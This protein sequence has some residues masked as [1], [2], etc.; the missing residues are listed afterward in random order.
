M[1]RRRAA[2]PRDLDAAS[3]I[4][5]ARGSE[6]ESDPPPPSP[7]PLQAV[8]HVLTPF[9]SDKP[10]I[11]IP[12]SPDVGCVDPGVLFGVGINVFVPFDRQ[13]G[14]R[15]SGPRTMSLIKVAIDA[16]TATSTGVA[17]RVIAL[18]PSWQ[19]HN[20]AIDGAETFH[21]RCTVSRE[22]KVSHT[23]R[24]NTTSEHF[25]PASRRLGISVPNFI[26]DEQHTCRP[27][28]NAFPLLLPISLL[29]PQHYTHAVVPQRTELCRSELSASEIMLCE[30]FFFSPEFPFY[31]ISTPL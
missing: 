31:A 7:P 28:S 27:P 17:I 12:K 10:Q 16:Y 20:S 29:P 22:N 26:P 30:P 3:G 9:P 14:P 6:G 2:C 11:E 19:G 15:R 8:R 24:S 23:S 4:R 21:K 1:N 5:D 18:R 25:A 13:T